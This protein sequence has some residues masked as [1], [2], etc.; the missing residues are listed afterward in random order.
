M[1]S[2][3]GA[4]FNHSLGQRP[5]V[6][7]QNASSAK[8]AIQCGRP[9]APSMERCKTHQIET[10]FQRLFGRQ[11]QFLGRYPRLKNKD[12]GSPPWCF[13]TSGDFADLLPV[14]SGSLNALVLFA[15][16]GTGSNIILDYVIRRLDAFFDWP[17]K[18]VGGLTFAE[19]SLARSPDSTGAPSHLKQAAVESAL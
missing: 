11:S 6:W 18:P 14:C 9:F 10:R 16:V 17:E 19:T 15:V 13:K 5:R 8:R 7:S 3:E 4:A 12:K 2:A 1:F